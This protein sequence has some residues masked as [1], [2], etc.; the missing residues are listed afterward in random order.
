MPRRVTHSSEDHA[1]DIF[2]KALAMHDAG[3]NFALAFVKSTDGG[4]V[5]RAGAVMLI[6]EKGQ[7]T[8]YVSGGC[9]DA[10]VCAQ[11]LYAM[12]DGKTRVIRYGSG[13]PYIDLKLPCGNGIDICIIAS[14][15]IKVIS[16]VLSQLDA[17]QESHFYIT[18]DGRLSLSKCH[19]SIQLYYTPK[20]RLRIGGRGHDAIALAHLAAASGLSVILQCPDREDLVRDLEN[21][22]MQHLVSFENIPEPQ[23]DPFTAFALMFHDLEWETALLTQALKGPAFYVGALGSRKTHQSR[24]EILHSLGISE[25]ETNRIKAPIGLVPAM[26]DS[27]MLAISTLADIV[28]AYHKAYP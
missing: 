11:A 27:S 21:V 6:D 2:R 25:N 24:C 19:N 26:R 10:D 12:Q 4:S 28:S 9:I 16:Y 13:S 17:R 1:E 8:G 15:N 5:R 3:I 14:P 23:D 22:K 18:Q 20:L 7:S